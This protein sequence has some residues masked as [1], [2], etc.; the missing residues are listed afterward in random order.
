MT[1]PP[2][3]RRRPV[4][5]GSRA[6][7]HVLAGLVLVQAVIAGRSDR[8]FGSWDI[9]AHERL[10]NVVF[11]V[12]L[13]GLVL[14]VVARQSRASIPVAAALLVLVTAQVGLGYAGRSTAEAAAWHIPNG[15]A[16]FGLAVYNITATRRA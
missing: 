9:A 7:A 6:A 8:L 15:V 5:T 4:V 10:G 1:T 13:V 16:I 2:A 11:L 12:A 3:P 14:A